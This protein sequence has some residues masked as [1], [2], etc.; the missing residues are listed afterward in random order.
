MNTLLERFTGGDLRSDGLANEVADLVVADT[1]LLPQLLDGLKEPDPLIRARTADALEKVSRVCPK[2]II[3]KLPPLTRLALT[4]EVPMVRWHIAMIFANLELDEDSSTWVIDI[5][6]QMLGDMSVFV[7]SWVISSLCILGRHVE[8]KR[9][10]IIDNI[11]CL[12][13]DDSVAVRSRV[14]NALACLENVE[15]PLPNGWSKTDAL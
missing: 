13:D 11:K 5:L 4:D 14:Q 2:L 1:N 6:I 7:R 15:K 9:E 3:D 10:E 8:D 12:E